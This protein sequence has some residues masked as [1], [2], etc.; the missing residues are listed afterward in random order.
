MVELAGVWMWPELQYS[1]NIREQA[2]TLAMRNL[3]ARCEPWPIR[4]TLPLRHCRRGLPVRSASHPRGLF[5]SILDVK[6]NKPVKI[7]RCDTC[8]E[9]IWD[10]M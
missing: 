7:F 6:R 8:R 4:P 10:G 2:F 3:N 1:R 9:E 5:T